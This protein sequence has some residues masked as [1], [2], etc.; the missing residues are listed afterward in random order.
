MKKPMNRGTV[1]NAGRFAQWLSEFSGYRN[2]VTQRMIELWLDQ[3]SPID[4]DLAARILTS[5]RELVGSLEGWDKAKL[6]RKGRWFFVP[7]SG[8]VGESGDVM[9]HALRMAMSMTSKRYDDLFIH[10]SELVGENPGPDDTVVLVD[11]FSGTG[12]QACGSW[13]IFEELLTGRPKI[14][15]MLVAATEDAVARIVDETEM[16]PVCA[17]ILRRKDGLFHP[18]CIHFTQGE[19]NTIL[20]YCTKADPREPRGFGK[21]GLLVVL[22][23]RTPNNTIPILQTSNDQW[24]GLFPRHD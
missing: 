23:H 7:F 2:P 22:A 5:F 19:K 12:A 16:E 1:L 4:L 14:V 21:T 15:L 11:D 24:Q 3:F 6:R 18:D 17:T 13:D 10:R 8:S 20:N 9:V